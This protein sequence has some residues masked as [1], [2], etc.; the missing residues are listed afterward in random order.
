MTLD[1]DALRRFRARIRAQAASAKP[2]PE[3]VDRL[4][5]L[6]TAVALRQARGNAPDLADAEAVRLAAKR[7][8]NAAEARTADG[9]AET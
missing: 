1:A 2:D 9:Q 7:A 3:R 6:L 5:A 4:A 8:R